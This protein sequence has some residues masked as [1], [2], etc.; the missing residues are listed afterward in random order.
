[1]ID[2]VFVTG[3]GT[4]VGK[5]MVSAWLVHS[6]K[7]DYWKPVQSGTVDTW[8][9][10][11]IRTVAPN[12][13]I[14]PSTIAL[15]APLSP[16]EAATLEGASISLDMFH[17]PR[18][19]RPL[20]VEGAGGA[21]VPLNDR[22]FMADLMKRL[23]LPVI[24][25]GSSGLGTINHTLLTIEALKRREIAIAGVILNG[26]PHPNNRAAIEHFG[27]VKVIAELPRLD[28]GPAALVNHPCVERLS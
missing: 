20:V 24:L 28:G 5:T 6:W 16:H 19:D 15:K 2:R 26:D 11:V 27:G 8:D 7:A 10:N 18:T 13:T 17:L 9:A 12:T 25:V 1:M 3:T 22:D 23:G 21:L 4:D 14:H